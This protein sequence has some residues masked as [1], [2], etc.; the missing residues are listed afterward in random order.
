VEG[1]EVVA[2]GG[3]ALRVYDT[4][5]PGA[6]YD[7]VLIWHHGSPQTG[8]SPVPLLPALAE[9]RIRCVSYDRPGY[10]RSQTQR[11]RDVAAAAADVAAIADAL[12]IERFA[13]IGASGGGPHALACAAL[14]PGRVT[15]AVSIAG[16]APLGAE[17]LD[18]YAGMADSGAEE[19]HAAARGR[20]ALE[21]HLASITEFDGDVFTAADFAALSEEWRWLGVMAEQAMASG[22][23]GLVDDDLAFVSAW[24]FDPS[25]I[26]VPVLLV[27]G[28]DDR[29]VPR[30]HGEWLAGHLD[31]AELWVRTGEGHI[32]ILRSCT[33]VLEWLLANGAASGVAHGL[34]VEPPASP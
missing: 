21:T 33:A 2:P 31:G 25:Q 3:Q 13:T 9:R 5:D 30:P 10:G 22:L 11:G 27:H 34:D 15:G 17:G 20:V 16:L 24:G 18:W 26:T 12:G 28:Q 7:M 23:D 4:G 19:L 8:A 14:L 1:C 6:E 32:S 29:I